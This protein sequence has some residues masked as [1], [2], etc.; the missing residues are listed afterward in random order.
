MEGTE[1]K[2][3]NIREVGEATV[4][5]S[6]SKPEG[7]EVA[8]GEFVQVGAPVDDSFVV[9]HYTVSS[10]YADGSFEIT[11]GIDEDGDLSPVLARL[12]EGDYVSVDGPFGRAYYEGE[13]DVVVIAGGPGVGPAVGIGERVADEKGAERVAVVYRDDEPAHTDRLGALRDEG[14]T[15]ELLGDGEPLRETVAEVV[16][17]AGDAQVFV[18]GFDGFVRE[19]TEALE[20]AGYDGE[21][22][23]ENFG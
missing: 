2:V 17:G 3:G 19:A 10:P 4:S 20:D 23:V 12:D 22:K 18:Y 21:P 7:W 6:L 15:V 1:V 13:D 5:I 11:V 9:R 14:A 16:G 8:P